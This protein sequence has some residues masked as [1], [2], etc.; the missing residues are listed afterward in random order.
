M[1]FLSHYYCHR[2]ASPHFNF[3]LLFPDF[4]GIVSRDYKLHA[5]EKDYRSPDDDFYRGM[6]H[7]EL[8]DSLWHYH[9][10]FNEKTH[11]I[12]ALLAAFGMKDKP[13]RPF[14]MTHVMLELLLDRQLVLHENAIA[15]SMYESLDE[16]EQ[17]FVAQLF[18]KDDL[19][20]KFQA[21]FQNFRKNRYVLSY[22]DNEMFV[23]ALNRLFSRVNHP[24]IQTHE[25][26]IFV[27]ELDKIVE[28]DYKQPLDAIS[29][30][31]IS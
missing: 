31:K 21:F 16:V 8:A 6:K 29:N 13:Y 20:Q 9:P 30:E 2:S 18:T 24:H 14:F 10:Y 1:N 17:D 26:D 28:N 27:S 15:L 4:L 11:Q 19:Q 5:F 12:K 22:A 23:Y 7:H 3:G 25:K